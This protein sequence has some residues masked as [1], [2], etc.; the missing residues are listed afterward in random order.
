MG[1]IRLKKGDAEAIAL[2]ERAIA[3][4][5][6]DRADEVYWRATTAP[7]HR[8]RL[9]D[10]RR[11]R[12]RRDARKAALADWDVLANIGLNQDGKAEAGIER[13]KLCYQLGDR[14]QALA[15]FEAAIDAAP[16]RGATY[17][18]VIAFLGAAR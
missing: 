10:P 7:Q 9:R 6:G 1:Q 8:R 12:R 18:D 2:F 17:A 5:K 11:R 14:D 13:A 16:D 3:L 15:N 4:P